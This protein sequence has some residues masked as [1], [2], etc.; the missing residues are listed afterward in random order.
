[1]PWYLNTRKSY[2]REF[3]FLI[4]IIYFHVNG[5]FHGIFSVY[6]LCNRDVICT[7][8]WSAYSL[9]SFR[10][11]IIIN[12]KII[13][14]EGRFPVQMGKILN[15]QKHRCRKIQ[16]GFRVPYDFPP[17]TKQISSSNIFYF[18]L[19]FYYDNCQIISFNKIQNKYCFSY[20]KA[21]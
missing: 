16:V 6:F 4:I 7:C 17:K 2:F 9:G 15:P 14:H 18:N 12:L 10:R 1:M 19:L 21:Y 13:L 5:T 11:R 8:R 20:I 3:F